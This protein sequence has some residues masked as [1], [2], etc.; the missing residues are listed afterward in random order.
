MNLL[1]RNS[2]TFKVGA[3]LILLLSISFL[4][5]YDFPKKID[6]KYAAYEYFTNNPNDGE[7]TSVTIVGTYKKPLFR[8]PSFT[9]K[10]M[11]EEYE[12]TQT[13]ELM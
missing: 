11:I 9:G 5:I 4:L 12:F 1:K 8:N 3:L 10:I 13:Y 6:R 2:N 7:T